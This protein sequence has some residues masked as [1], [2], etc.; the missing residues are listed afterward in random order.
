MRS[1]HFS[2]RK[3]TPM[4][5]KKDDDKNQKPKAADTSRDEPKPKPKAADE[6][7]PDVQDEVTADHDE[8]KPNPVNPA[9]PQDP[10]PDDMQVSHN[11]TPQGDAVLIVDPMLAPEAQQPGEPYADW[12]RR[13]G[14]K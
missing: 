2:C 3:E 11:F 7:Q 8:L 9:R 14:Q 6:P 1:P 13:T 4:P 5:A 10:D 12:Q